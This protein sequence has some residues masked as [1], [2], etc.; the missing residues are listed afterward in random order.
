[1]NQEIQFCSKNTKLA[2]SLF[3][4]DVKWGLFCYKETIFKPVPV[5]VPETGTEIVPEMV[6]EMVPKTVPA[7]IPETVLE[8]EN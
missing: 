7:V 5:L 3:E 1:M 8:M 2:D 6:R 4:F